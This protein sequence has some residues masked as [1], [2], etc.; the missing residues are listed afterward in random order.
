MSESELN[1]L[2][3][4]FV[5][6]Y[7]SDIKQKDTEWYRLMGTTVG[8]S[9]IAAIM[10]LNRYTS[11]YGVI[12][13]KIEI[14]KGTKNFN[15]SNDISCCWGTIF[16]NVIERYVSI[17]LG[18]E[19]KGTK[20]CIQKYEGHRNSPD[21]YVVA[22]FYLKDNVYHIWTTDMPREMIM[23]SMI[24]L[25]EFKCPISRRPT[26][27]VPKYYKPQVLSGLAVSPVAHKGLFVDA[28]FKK[29]SLDQLGD[30]G[31]YD[32]VFHKKTVT[33]LLP[34]AWGIIPVYAPTSKITDNIKEMYESHFNI[35]FN[36]ENN[37][38]IDLGDT[39]I[40]LFKKMMKAMSEKELIPT[41]PTIKFLDGRGDIDCLEIGD[42]PNCILFALLPWKLFDVSYVPIDREPN[43]LENIYP[44]IQTVHATVKECIENNITIDRLKINDICDAIYT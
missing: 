35:N 25:L 43:F 19:V 28:I 41:R 4:D 39:T 7:N 29:C 34:I 8:G 14:C 23:L 15:S 22:N 5:N 3:D 38:V 13:S 36:E 37:N 32:I 42:K 17:D 33:N 21:G 31:K 16:E 12:E 20:M 6:I 30:N 27:D 40:E 18:N 44:L 11:Y 24:L 10:S 26:G 9:E 2:I 1:Q